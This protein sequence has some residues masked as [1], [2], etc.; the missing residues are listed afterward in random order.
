[1]VALGV[2]LLLIAAVV[3]IA[4][5]LRGGAAVSM[6]LGWF[7]IN[8]HAYVVF[9]AGAV[10]LLLTLA[11][12]ALMLGG[13]KRGRRRRSEVKGLRKRAETSEEIA[14]REHEANAARERQ[15]PRSTGSGRT[16]E[17]DDHYNTAPRDP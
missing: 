15:A 6:D 13:A 17:P 7:T 11:G 14:R 5:I 3:V 16:D 10:T 12:L 9:F 1:M 8:T 4:T 2:L